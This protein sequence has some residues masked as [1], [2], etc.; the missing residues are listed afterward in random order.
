MPSSFCSE[1]CPAGMARKYQVRLNLV[2]PGEKGFLT[3][4]LVLR[5]ARAVAG[6]VAHVESFKWEKVD[7]KT[8]ARIHENDYLF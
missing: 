3:Q 8:L 5:K 6:I 4:L 2:G 7:L 1:E